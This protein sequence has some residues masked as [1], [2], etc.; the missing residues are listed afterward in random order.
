MAILAGSVL[1]APAPALPPHAPVV[2]V[3]V[4]SSLPVTTAM[5]VLVEQRSKR[6]QATPLKPVGAT[7]F[8]QRD[9]LAHR[10]RTGSMGTRRRRR[11]DNDHFTDHPL[12]SKHHADPEFFTRDDRLPG[13]T[14]PRPA[15][16]FAKLP[17]G[18]VSSLP[19]DPNHQDPTTTDLAPAAAPGE[20]NLTRQDRRLRTQ[21]RRSG[22]ARDVVRRFEGEILAKVLPLPVS[23][24]A[25]DAAEWETGEDL[26]LDLDKDA[27][28]WILLPVDVDDG[29]ATVVDVTCPPIPDVAVVSTGEEGRGTTTTSRASAS[30]CLEITDAFVRLIV[31]AMCRY[32]RLASHSLDHGNGKRLTYISPGRP[33]STL[34]GDDRDEVVAKPSCASFFEYIFA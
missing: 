15:S 25:S 30:L 12:V 17:P 3:F 29:L 21:I 18:L 16:P 1:G 10:E 23:T 4:A 20:A 7:W 5:A 28:S 31:H 2:E 8:L 9:S 22:C 24:S 34:V 13:Y 32:H 14:L 11:F 33:T 27:A 26:D 19:L 6:K